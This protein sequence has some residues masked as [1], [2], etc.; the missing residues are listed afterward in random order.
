MVTTTQTQ[1]RGHFARRDFLRYFGA[2]AL[3]VALAGCSSSNT[4]PFAP[5]PAAGSK[6]GGKALRGLFP[7]LTTPFTVDD[8]LD[9][10]CLANEVKFCNKGGVHGLAWPQIASGWTS[11][12]EAE[13]MTGAEA[14]LAAG[15]GGKTAI[16]IG[17]QSQD[18]NMQTVER[19]AKHAAKYGADAI[20]SLPPPGVTDEKA[21]LTY[22][23]QVGKMTELPLVMQTQDQMSVDLVVQ[24]YKTIPNCRTVKDEAA[25]GGG[26]L[27]RVTEILRQTNNEMRVFS[28][29]GVRTMIN[30]MELGFSGHCPTVVLADIYAQAFDLY[31]AGKKVEAFAMFGRIQAF[32]TMNLNTGN[33][34][35][36]ARGMFKLTTRSRATPGMGGGGGGGGA[37]GGGGAGRGGAGGGGAAGGGGRGG[38]GRGGAGGGAAGGSAG[39]ARSP[40]EEVA[41]IRKALDTYLKPYLRGDLV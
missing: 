3:G 41:A 37:A 30:E 18:G 2:G 31:H 39:P 35:M 25:S 20:V 23:Q 29:Q 32:G 26:P 27:Q 15:K 28:G 11:L 38:A 34:M 5:A 13:R 7:I 8:K 40:A 1:N 6:P 10:E 19:Y 36:V 12:S 16:V 24:A 14:L 22:Y 9:L 17:V 4:N 21:L 33:P